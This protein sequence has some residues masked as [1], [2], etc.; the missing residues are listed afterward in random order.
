MVRTQAQGAAPPERRG[1]RGAAAS[2]AETRKELR[3][4]RCTAPSAPPASSWVTRVMQSRITGLP[5]P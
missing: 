2:P 3:M 4:A 5:A 1:Q